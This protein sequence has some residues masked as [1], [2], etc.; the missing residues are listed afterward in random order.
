[1]SAPSSS[2]HLSAA[3]SVRLDKWLWAARF[4][5]TRSLAKQAI[6][7][8][9]VRYDGEAAKVSKSVEIGATLRLRQGHD[10][11]EVIVR[12]LSDHRGA[13]TLARLLYE[14]TADSCERRERAALERKAASGFVSAERP[15]KQ[16][17]RAIHRFKREFLE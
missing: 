16:Q 12:A 10:D 9:K 8:G 11:V 4:F 1:M 2:A 15:S 17:R 14:E 7:R 13:A 3:A 6:E 5:K